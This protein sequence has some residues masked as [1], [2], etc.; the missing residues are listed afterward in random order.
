MRKSL[1]I[2]ALKQAVVRIK[3]SE[4]LLAHSDRGAQYASH[5][6]QKVKSVEKE[7]L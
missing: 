2:S 6:Y 5:A 7:W 1:V 4:G 3:A